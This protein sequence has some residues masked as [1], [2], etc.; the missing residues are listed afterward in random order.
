MF[1]GVGC[2]ACA[3]GT[4]ASATSAATPAILFEY[5]MFFRSPSGCTRVHGGWRCSA[6]ASVIGATVWMSGRRAAL[7]GPV[8][9]HVAEA[10]IERGLCLLD[11]AVRSAR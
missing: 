10:S 4:A 7:L 1:T 3:A 6:A 11:S 5:L 2:A 9:G 8:R